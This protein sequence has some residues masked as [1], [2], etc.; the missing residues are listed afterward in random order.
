MNLDSIGQIQNPNLF[1]TVKKFLC[2]IRQK[3]KE[4]KSKGYILIVSGGVLSQISDPYSDL[5]QSV[6]Y[7]GEETSK[8]D[9]LTVVT[10]DCPTKQ[11]DL[12]K[13][14]NNEEFLIPMFAQGPGYEKMSRAQELFDA[15]KQ[16]RAILKTKL[17]GDEDKGLDTNEN[18]K[19]MSR[20]V[21]ST[22]AFDAVKMPRNGCFKIITN[23]FNIILLHTIVGN[24]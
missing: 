22:V 10:G 15:P 14:T 4:S 21:Q 12:L 8:N 5:V 6:K 16:I 17:F 7:V 23:Y 24:L 19:W 18:G 11:E 9:T 2:R 13:R 3:A 20:R 1:Q